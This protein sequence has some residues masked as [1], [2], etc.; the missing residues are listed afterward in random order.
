M[1]NFISIRKKDELRRLEEEHQ[2]NKY[3]HQKE[4]KD[5]IDR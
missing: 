3:L 2:E 4:Y 1:F 5:K